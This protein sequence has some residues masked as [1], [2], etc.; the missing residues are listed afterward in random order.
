MITQERIPKVVYQLHIQ[1]DTQEHLVL[2]RAVLLSVGYEDKDLVTCVAQ[3]KPSIEL[4]DEQKTKL[5]QVEKLL[6]C[7]HLSGIHI[8]MRRLLPSDWLT[9]WKRQWKPARLTKLLDVVP[10]WYKGR[11]KPKKSRDYILM[12]TLL[13][14]GTG[15]HETTQ[16]MAQFIEDKQGAFSSLLDIGTG[17]GIL[18]LVALKY[19]ARYVCGIDIGELSIQAAGDNMKANSL[20]FDIKR[21]DIKTFRSKKKFDF[22]AANLI[23][24][25]LITHAKKMISFVKRGGFLAVSGISLDHLK[26]LRLAFSSLGLKTLKIS[27]GK[28]WSGVLYQKTML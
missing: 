2:A 23:T 18:G 14:F 21:A 3:D 9:R 22:V 1:S 20:H 12:D 6:S 25:D 13:S 17:T 28:E 4:F 26:R 10:V 11:Y 7:L 15:L 5:L 16:I 27:K 24:E 19:G 8:H